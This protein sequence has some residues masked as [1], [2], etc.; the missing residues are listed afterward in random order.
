MNTKAVFSLSAVNSPTT[1]VA[2]PVVQSSPNTITVLT[3]SG[4]VGHTGSVSYTRAAATMVSET[5]VIANKK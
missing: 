2:Q 1:T 5:Y 4:T 3:T